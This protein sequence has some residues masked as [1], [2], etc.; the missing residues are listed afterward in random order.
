ML[1]EITKLYFIMGLL[2]IGLGLPLYFKKIK[3][4]RWYGFRTRKTLS[5]PEIWYAANKISGLDI[6]I[7]GVVTSIAA[8]K[9]YFLGIIFPVLPIAGLNF[10][11][12]I[13][14]TLAAVVHSFWAL[15]RIK[16]NVENF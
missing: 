12:F 13:L 15:S 3:P 9:L 14:A 11:V 10:L 6:T 16:N 1:L 8:I 4:N 2:Y 7:A 5:D